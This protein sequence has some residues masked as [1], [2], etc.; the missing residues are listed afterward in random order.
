MNVLVNAPHGAKDASTT[1]N[2]AKGLHTVTPCVSD[3][4]I[5]SRGSYESFV[6]ATSEKRM[7]AERQSP[8][9]HLQENSI[10]PCEFFSVH[11]LD[12]EITANIDAISGAK[13]IIR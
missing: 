6:N 8:E 2:S 1:I 11:N 5:I 12:V 10:G 7:L 3:G 9:Q 4:N 13:I